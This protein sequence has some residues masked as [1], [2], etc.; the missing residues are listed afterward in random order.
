MR[1]LVV[2]SLL[3]PSLCFSRKTLERPPKL[4][5]VSSMPENFYRRHPLLEIVD[6]P[7][8]FTR[9]EQ[10]LAMQE[11]IS[12]H[13]ISNAEELSNESSS[14]GK[15]SMAASIFN[16]VNNVAGAGIL[17]LSSGVAKGTG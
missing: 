11:E 10:I 9:E 2:L 16:L 3:L 12:Q 4:E 1:L 8:A 5:K 6:H 17:T 7:V 13:G 14:E 15:S